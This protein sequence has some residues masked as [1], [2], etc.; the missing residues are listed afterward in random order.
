MYNATRN[1]DIN[2]NVKH[3]VKKN[4]VVTKKPENKS[5]SELFKT[6]GNKE[7]RDDIIFISIITW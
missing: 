5:I 4:W 3:K 6:V 1:V 7:R 2:N